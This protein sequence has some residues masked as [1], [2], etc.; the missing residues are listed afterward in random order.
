M[1]A[2][3]ARARELGGLGDGPLPDGFASLES[4]LSVL[5][6]TFGWGDV[7]AILEHGTRSA[8][9]EGPDSPWRPVITWALGWAHY[10]NGDLDEAE[11][12]L[13]ETTELAPRVGPMDRRRRRDRRPLADRRPARAAGR[14]DAPGAE[15]VELAGESGCS[16]PSRTARC[17]RP[18]AS[19]CSPTGVRRGA[20]RAGEGRVPAPALGPAARPHRRPDR[21]ARPWGRDGRPRPRRGPARRGAALGGGL[22]RPG[23]LPRALAT[24]RRA[25]RIGAR[26]TRPDRAQRARARPSCAFWARGLS[27][28]EIGD[29]ST[30]RSTPCTATS[31]RS[32]ASSG[33]RRAP[34]PWH[35]RGT[36]R[37][38]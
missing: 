8:E 23:A 20:R 33:C 4:S 17:T 27:E 10:C 1:R 13:T 36:Q 22:P 31:R 34:T 18:T 3:M 6:A 25:A 5:S 2:A 15:A 7:S 14:A 11:R 9:L 16:T 29:G 32:T 12:W 38:R 24:A 35:V 30:S 28:R 21:A 19:R 37:L 26:A